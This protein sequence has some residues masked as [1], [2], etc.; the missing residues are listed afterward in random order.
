MKVSRLIN[1]IQK[2]GL[3]IEKTSDSNIVKVIGP[4]HY[5]SFHIQGENAICVSTCP[6][7]VESDSMI[8]Y[9]PASYHRT[10]KSFVETMTGQ[11]HLNKEQKSYFQTLLKMGRSTARAFEEAK[12]Y[13]GFPKS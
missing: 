8:D 13:E 7:G 9:F 12:A 10:I 3:K 5:G 11:H 6:N 4:S 2:S 1:A